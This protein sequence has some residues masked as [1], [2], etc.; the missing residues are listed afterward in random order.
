MSTRRTEKDKGG[1]RGRVRASRSG[2]DA[3]GAAEASG[4]YVYCVGARAELARLFDEGLPDAIEPGAP[5]ELVAE[6]E[7]AAVASAVPLS[8][9]GEE[10]LAARLADPEWIAV[11]AMRHERVVEHFARRAGIAPLRF[12]TIYLRREGAARMLAER[13]NDLSAAV[14]RL[15]GREE[16]GVNVYWDR[17]KLLER[18]AELSPRL[19][20]LNERAASLP[21]GRAYLLRK[22]V[23]ALRA[24]EA[25]EEV[26]RATGEIERR[27]GAASDARARLRVSSAEAAEGRELAAKFAFLVERARFAEFRAAAEELARERADAGLRLELAG[28]LPA[29]SFV[30]VA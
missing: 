15:R 17:A 14:A 29:Y 21:P 2:G 30:A 5:L 12:G 22:Q 6:G 13:R 25:R 28:P 18:I 8:D 4:F 23:D 16:W 26:A 27:L 20:E 24:D 10:R 19:R 3:C 7:L 11:R 1:P 9:Y